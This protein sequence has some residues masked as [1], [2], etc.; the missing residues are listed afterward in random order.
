M[1]TF[2]NVFL[3]Y[4]QFGLCLGSMVDSDLERRRHNVSSFSNAKR[5][6]PVVHVTCEQYSMS[7]SGISYL[8]MSGQQCHKPE[9]QNIYEHL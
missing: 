1:T 5:I 6:I 3:H 9:G 8:E 2:L 4:A 7:Q